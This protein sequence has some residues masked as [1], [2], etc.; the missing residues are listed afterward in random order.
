[1]A[2]PSMSELL[3]KAVRALP[4]DEQDAILGGLLYRAS[5]T[6]PP[7]MPSPPGGRGPWTHVLT[8]LDWPTT[9]LPR[10]TERGSTLRV[11][12]VRLSAEQHDALKQWC[13]SNDFSM[14]T[15][16]RGLVDRFLATQNRPD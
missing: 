9:N 10:L 3:V 4:Q 15:V 16:I 6:R 14:A 12:P 7:A 2:E 11:V 5:E 13:E 8:D 1:V